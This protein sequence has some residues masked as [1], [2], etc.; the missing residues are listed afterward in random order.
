MLVLAASAMIFAMAISGSV[1]MRS[2]TIEASSMHDRTALLRD[3]RSAMALALAGLTAAAGDA[4]DPLVTA[5][6][7]GGAGGDEPSSA[8][9]I[10]LPLY[11][12]GMPFT[13]GAT[14][15][16]ED[17]GGSGVSGVSGVNGAP[18][19]KPRG[20]FS[21]LRQT[22]LP[23][24]A[25]T[26]E[27]NNASYRVTIEDSRGG[28]DINRADEQR[29]VDYFNLMGISQSRAVAIAHQIT[30][31]RDDDDF[32]RPQGAER[33]EYRRRNIAIANARFDTIDEL[34]FL[35][36]MTSEI[37]DLI[38]GDVCVGS[39]GKTYIGAS[40]QALASVP[41]I[42]GS[43]VRAIEARRRAGGQ[44]SSLELRDMLGLAYE[45]AGPNLRTTPSGNLRVIVEPIAHQGVR[46][47]SEASVTDRRGIRIGAVTLR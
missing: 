39:D 36:A 11:P 34:R 17:E 37:F 23:S 41:G 7:G 18:Q 30:D 47:V 21:A 9:E 32:R 6:D 45:T 8:D 2:A 14:G 24:S 19:S 10:D 44:I 29:L 31:W 16:N 46:L 4:D 5:D 3:A 1:A 15:E 22:G 40:P 20:A 28:V 38:R 42:T 26:I 35:P 27:I 12:S 13:I 25:I 43:A 33:E